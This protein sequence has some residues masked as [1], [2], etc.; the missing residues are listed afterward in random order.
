MVEEGLSP[1]FASISTS[2]RITL[3][4]L[5]PGPYDAA[6]KGADRLEDRAGFVALLL[7]HCWQR[8]PHHSRRER[9]SVCA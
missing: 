9:A 8:D 2:R 6:V 1:S 4:Q 3:E 5:S 7:P